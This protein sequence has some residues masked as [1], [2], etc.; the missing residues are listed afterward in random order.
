MLLN[1]T[2]YGPVSD[3]LAKAGAIDLSSQGFD[4]VYIGKGISKAGAAQ[5]A[6]KLFQQGVLGDK[7]EEAE[8]FVFDNMPDRYRY[9][10][11]D[12]VLCNDYCIMRVTV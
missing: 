4:Y 11:S 2:Y 12:G 6:L 9:L 1:V 10:T 3:E 7:F 5:N 8:D